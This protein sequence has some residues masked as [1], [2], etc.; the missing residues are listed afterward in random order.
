MHYLVYRST[1]LV[2]PG[3]FRYGGI[4][5]TSV[6]NNAETGITGYL[7]YEEGEFLQYIEG[8]DAAISAL[9]ARL[10]RDPRHRDILL[11]AS[12]AL[13]RRRFEDWRMGMS[14]PT[15]LSLATFLRDVDHP[16]CRPGPD[17][18]EAIYFLL[19]V[20]Q[21]IELGLADPPR[22]RQGG[23]RPQLSPVSSVVPPS[24]SASASL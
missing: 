1:A 19:S 9:W 16:Q 3:S 22:P 15:V 5:H 4:L 18:A 12:G 20:C 17:G 24:A 10:A 11:L 2:S 8:P 13:A 7:H 14:D 6:R 21:R 23:P